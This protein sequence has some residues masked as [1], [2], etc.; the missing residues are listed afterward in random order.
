MICDECGAK[1][2]IGDWP[3]CKGDPLAHKPGQSGFG[4]DPFTPYVDPHILPFSDP[5]AHAEEFNAALGRVVRGTKIESREQRKALMREQG[6]DWAGRTCESGG[7]E[8]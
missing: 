1:L 4:F 3:F 7:R 5:R 2:R 6:L 8:V